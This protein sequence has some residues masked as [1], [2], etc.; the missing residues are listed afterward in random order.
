MDRLRNKNLQSSANDFY[1]FKRIF[2]IFGI[3]YPDDTLC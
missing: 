2:A 1:K 3:C